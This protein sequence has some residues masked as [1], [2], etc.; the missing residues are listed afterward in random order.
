MEK[1]LGIFFAEGELWHE[2]RRFALRH[3][4][5]FGF[6]RRFGELE[7]EINEELLQF[8]D[9]L[10]NGPKYD[11]EK[12]CFGKGSKN[13]GLLPVERL[14]RLFPLNK[15]GVVYRDLESH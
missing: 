6:G 4:R 14:G 11:F 2:Q 12:V 8:V 5:D 3:L 10:R 13:L 9:Y 15:T 7:V 1:F